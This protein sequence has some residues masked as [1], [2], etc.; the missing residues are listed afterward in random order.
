MALTSQKTNFVYFLY[1]EEQLRE[2]N[3]IL[4][5]R[6]KEFVP[7]TVYVGSSRL[8][9]TQQSNSETMDKYFDTKIVAKG[10]LGKMRFKS[11]ITR[12]IEGGL[13]E[14]ETD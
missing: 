5:P 10:I 13:E 1:S 6:G 7:G 9:Y 3:E 2:K 4:R 14:H 8:K 11:P 12:D